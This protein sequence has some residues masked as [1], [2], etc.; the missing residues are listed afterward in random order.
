MGKVFT[1]H[2]IQTGSIP[3]R[4]GFA[5]V[6]RM[7]R[8]ELVA[9]PCVLAALIHGSFQRG[10]YGERSDIDV[11]LIYAY[12]GHDEIM[13][14]QQRL[15]VAAQTRFVPI[16]IIAIDSEMAGAGDHTFFPMYHAHLCEAACAGGVV[17]YDPIAFI[18]PKMMTYH[19]EAHSYLTRKSN[20]F[21]RIGE[22][23]LVV[24]EEQ[25]VIALSKALSFATHAARKMLQC[26]APDLLGTSDGKA[27]VV[28][29]YPRLGIPD[30]TNVFY[31]LIGLDRMYS[32]ILTEPKSRLDATRYAVLLEQLKK[33]IPLARQF[34]RSNLRALR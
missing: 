31:E 1:W 10:D 12:E 3:R 15:Q 8:E 24:S 6:E 27:A 34:A 16:R 19:Q 9:S 5:S 21:D 2:E 25:L 22:S 18:A 20:G 26:L 13:A 7:L 4:E 14:L 23:L 11:V 17:K 30:T 29:L 28:T 33:S 32:E